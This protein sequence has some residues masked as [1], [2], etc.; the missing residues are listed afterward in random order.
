VRIAV[1]GLL[2]ES[3]T[4]ASSSCRFEDFLAADYAVGD[5]IIEHWKDAH[6]EL[7]GMIAGVMEQ[8][9]ELVPTFAASATPSGPVQ[10]Q[11][12][13]KLMSIL[14]S[15]L[16]KAGPID[17]LL[18]ALHGSM[19]SEGLESADG[20]TAR[21]IRAAIGNSVP[22]VMTL[23]MH[24]NISDPMILA[25]DATIAYRTYPHVDQRERGREA[26]RHMAD[27]LL[28]RRRPAQVMIKLPMVIHIVRQYTGDGAMKGLMDAVEEVSTR[29]GIRSASLA[30]GYIYADVPD[31]GV[32]LIVVA[33]SSDELAEQACWELA[34]LALSLKDELNA[35]L[36]TVESAVSEAMK[37]GG[38]VTLM[39]CGDNIGG[40][41]P[42][43][44]TILFEEARRQGLSPVGVILHDPAAAAACHE[45][46]VGA[47][48]DLQVGG[49][50]GPEHGGPAHVAGVV[51]YI[52]DGHYTEDQPRHGGHRFFNQGACAVIR[53]DDG[54]LILVNSLRV[55]PTSLG[56]WVSVGVKL[57]SL[58]AV[59]VKG[60]T[61]PL[62]AYAPISSRVIAVDS[63]GVTRAGPE[64]FVYH[65]RP[66]PL[67]PLEDG[68]APSRG[69]CSIVRALPRVYD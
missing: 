61:A 48:V 28:H 30:P 16:R 12:Y 25:P 32:S 36:P 24:A 26:A 68:F 21:R 31:M 6:H 1:T 52:G 57:E 63:P 58:R 62:A 23:D 65:R 38:L 55:M 50:S 5:A 22:M 15:E 13:E 47:R 60:A 29:P 69:D 34:D 11:A 59:L 4:F 27:I 3:N 2:H 33:E 37:A 9:L 40:G 51:V 19:F 45:A 43:D 64:A 20:E 17:G 42:G 41:G 35:G 44:A 54:D 46:G 8:K 39:D 67:F 49:R 7:G 56:Q 53:T 66:R 14:L 18:V 10:P